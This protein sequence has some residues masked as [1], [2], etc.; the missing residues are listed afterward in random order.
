MSRAAPHDRVWLFDLDNTLHDAS[1]A[2]FGQLNVGMTDYI[3]RELGLTRAEADAL[4]RRYWLRYGATLLGLMRHHGVDAAHFLEQT[5]VLPGLEERVR[6][7]AHDF[8]ALARLP[9]RKV[10]LT[11]A[12]ALYTRRVL[13]VLG[14]THLFD[15]VIPIEDMRVFGQL[16]PKPDTRMLRRVAARLK[17]P[18]ERC[19][20]VEDTLGHLKAARSVGMGTVWMQRFARRARVAMPVASR[21]TLAP[22]YVDRRIS[23]LA[24]LLRG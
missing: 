2:A 19:I 9:G 23:R 5:H 12:P 13:G 24:T 22:P 1:H 17:V 15:L 4:R 10:L 6:G 14:I 3:E 21:L 20:L 7:H 8:A 16:R 18:P 11:N